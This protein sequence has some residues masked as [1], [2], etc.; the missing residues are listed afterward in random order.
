MRLKPGLATLS[1]AGILT[2]SIFV[3]APVVLPATDPARLAGAPVQSDPSLAAPLTPPPLPG[4]RD[5][6][7]L[8]PRSTSRHSP[9]ALTPTGA[10]GHKPAEKEKGQEK[11]E[12]EKEE[13][14]TANPSVPSP[15][16]EFDLSSFNV[17][18]SSHSAPG[19]TKPQMAPGVTRIRWAAG[20]L[21][22]HGVDVVGFQE[23]QLDQVRAFVRIRGGTYDVYPGSSAGGKAAQNSIAWRT[24]MWERVRAY[25][26]PIFYFNGS[27]M[28]MPVVLLRHRAT[29]VSAYFTN[30]HNPA[31]T[32]RHPNQERWRRL[33]LLQEVALV[34]RLRRESGYPVFLMGDLNEKEEAFCTMTGRTAM[35]AANGG[36]SAGP[37][38][39]P[40]PIGIDWIFG[41]GGVTFSNYRADRSPTVSRTTDHPMVVSRVR[42]GGGGQGG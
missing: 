37:C 19:G 14:Q 30:F 13:S 29:G 26:V 17:L 25:T 41:S 40:R 35:V 16:L 6:A 36:I 8:T 31:S 27:R 21:D 32:R 34:N 4:L 11:H 12:E 2:V 22:R 39:P 3:I 9:A 38:R 7:A 15:L 5:A 24:D 18:G 1:T 20:L 23:I 28:P 42:I 33:A 10:R